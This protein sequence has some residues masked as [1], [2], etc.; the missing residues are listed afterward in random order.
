LT[1]YESGFEP[2]GDARMKFDIIYWII[3]LLYLVFDLE[4]IFLFPFGAIIPHVDSLLSY[5]S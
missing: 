3:G 4:I 1:A 2:L 5:W